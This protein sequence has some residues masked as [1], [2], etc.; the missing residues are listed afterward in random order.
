MTTITVTDL[1]NIAVRC[2][3]DFFNH[4]VPLNEGLAKV[5]SEMDLNSDQLKRAIEA[6]NTLTHLKSIEVSGDRTSEFS[7]ANYENIVKLASIPETIAKAGAP[8]FEVIE[9]TAQ[10]TS[11]GKIINEPSLDK[12]AFSMPEM[13][14]K[15]KIL[16][17]TKYSSANKRALEDANQRLYDLSVEIIKVAKDLKKDPELVEHLSATDATDVEFQKIAKLLVGN[18]IPRKDFVQGMFKSAQLSKVQTFVSLYKEASNTR[19]EIME[20]TK[21]NDRLEPL[22]KKA[23]LAGALASGIGRSLGFLSRKTVNLANTV[24]VK[25]IAKTIGAVGDK[26]GT[27]IQNKVAKSPIGQELKIPERVVK[28]INKKIMR[29]GLILGGAATDA[30]SWSPSVNPANDRSGSVWAALQGQS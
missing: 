27:S 10:E 24:T 26:I 9:K 18:E 5:A 22:L 14:V 29:G 1:Q 16:H 23:G 12:L 30:I 8:K 15:E 6:T 7:P 28:P 17:L 20:R 2:T 13:S 21:L 19:A 11:P 25:P 3:S 4:G